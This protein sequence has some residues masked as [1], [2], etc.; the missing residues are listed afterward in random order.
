[1]EVIELEYVYCQREEQ[2]IEAL[3]RKLQHEVGGNRRPYATRGGGIDLVTFLEIAI[4]FTAGPVLSK[5]FE[6][7]FNAEALKQLGERHRQQISEWFLKLESD[8]SLLLRTVQYL[9]DIERIPLSFEEERA[10]AI[11]IKLGRCDLYVVLNH[12]TRTPRLLL[13]LPKGII[14]AIRFLAEKGVPEDAVVFQLYFDKISQEWKYLLVP[15]RKGFG[16]WVDRYIDLDSEQVK[17]ISSPHEFIELFQPS[18]QDKYKFLITPL[19]R[20]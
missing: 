11:K 8:S 18:M 10:F 17:Q 13:N 20:S 2:A 7:L 9:L 15:S 19:K 14:K 12:V 16:H 3:L 1:M 6:G 5:Y 4:S